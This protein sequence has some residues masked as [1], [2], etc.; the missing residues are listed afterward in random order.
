MNSKVLNSKV[1]N[2]EL[3]NNKVRKQQE[4]GYNILM[5]TAKNDVWPIPETEPQRTICFALARLRRQLIAGDGVG[6]ADDICDLYFSIVNGEVTI[7]D[8]KAR[9]S[10]GHYARTATIGMYTHTI[11]RLFAL[12]H[13]EE[14][15]KQATRHI[16]HAIVHLFPP[17]VLLRAIDEVVAARD[18][19]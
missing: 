10:I 8:L 1:R 4:S 5:T 12:G 13:S 17:E 15:V 9:N 18:E 19:T 6:D 3:P 7:R 2:N 16:T 11:H 14:Y